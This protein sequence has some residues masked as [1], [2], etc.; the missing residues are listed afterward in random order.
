MLKHIIVGMSEYQIVNNNEIKNKIIDLTRDLHITAWIFFII[1]LPTFCMGY[2]DFTGINLNRYIKVNGKI[3]NIY[4]AIFTYNNVEQDCKFL[5]AEPCGVTDNACDNY[6]KLNYP[7][8]SNI[9]LYYD[10]QTAYC[11]TERFV[12]NLFIVGTVFLSL[13]L[14]L[15]CYKIYL[16]MYYNITEEDFNN[17]PILVNELKKKERKYIL[18]KNYQNNDCTI[19]LANMNSNDVAVLNCGHCFHENCI[20]E[21]IKHNKD[22]P[23][24]KS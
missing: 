16:I 20:K 19:C 6:G 13:S 7:I 15:W 18:I 8:G 14:I 3:D 5:I 21:Q 9:T 4:H 17:S 12:N 22:C 11:R 24:L 1:G 10:T 23:L 2:N